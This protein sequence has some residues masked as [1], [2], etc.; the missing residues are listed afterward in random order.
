MSLQNTYNASDYKSVVT[1][2]QLL[3]ITLCVKLIILIQK[4]Y[5]VEDEIISIGCHFS[6][7]TQRYKMKIRL[8]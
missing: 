8:M 6:Y 1:T 5:S 7:Y 3:G 2:R 4:H